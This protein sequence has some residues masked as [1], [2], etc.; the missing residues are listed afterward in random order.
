MCG[1]CPANGELENGDPESPVDFLCHVAHLRAHAFGLPIPAHGECDYCEGGREYGPL[2][3]SAERLKTMAPGVVSSKSAFLPMAASQNS[4]HSA[5][6][7]SGGCSSCRAG[8]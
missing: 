4:A 3:A 1:M 2:M 6:C 7:G 8:N 5:S